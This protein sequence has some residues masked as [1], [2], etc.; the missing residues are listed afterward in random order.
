MHVNESGVTITGPEEYKLKQWFI[1]L[2][3][4][5]NVVR[6]AGRKETSLKHSPEWN[7]N[8]EL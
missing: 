5:R 1:I 2:S 4:G 3:G 7:R 6:E 8:P